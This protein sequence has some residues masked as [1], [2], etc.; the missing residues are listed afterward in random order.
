MKSA[1]WLALFALLAACKGDT[2]APGGKGDPGDPG[3]TGPGGSAAP[4]TGTLT[5]VVTDGIAHDALTSVAVT[6]TD[7]GGGALASATT[8]ASGKFSVTV[9]AGPVELTFVKA[10]Y[11]SPG[12]LQ[13]GVGIGET[14]QVAV[15]MNEAASGKPSLLLSA[16]GDDFGYGGSAAL[17]ATAADPN[18]DTLTYAWSNAGDPPLGTVSGN[19]ATGTIAFPT[20]AQAFASRADST[21]MQI[22]GYAIENRFGII[23]IITDTRGQVT[24]SLVVADGRGQATTASLTLNAAS[25][26]TG[27]R[28]VAVGQRIYLNSGH[29]TSNAWTLTAMPTGSSAA[30]DDPTLRT[31]SFV[32]DKVGEYSLTE[33]TH[34][35]TIT[36]SRWYGAITGGSGDSVTVDNTCL[37][38]HQNLSLSWIPDKFSPWLQTGH[39]TMFTRGINGELGSHYSGACIGCHTVGYDPGV[40]SGGFDEVAAANNWTFPVMQPTNWT[41][42]VA[43]EP[44]LAKLANIQC[45]NCHGPQGG[46]TA[47]TYSDAHM[48]T[49]I[50]P[51]T[52]RVS[53]PFQSPRISYSAELCGT[54]H[55][56][57]DHHIYSDWSTLSDDGMGHANRIAAQTIGSS[58]TT[59]SSSCGR[60]HTA[61]GYSLYSNLLKQNIVTMTCSP[62]ATCDPLGLLPT[63]ATLAQ[64]T[65]ANAE[66]VTC[67]S[68]HDPHDAT[69]PNQ[70][71]VYDSIAMTPAG[72]GVFGMGKGAVCVSCHNSRN[73][74]IATSDTFTYLHEDGQTY[75]GGNPTAYSAPHEADQ[76]D[77]FMGHNA[78]FMG[79]NMPMTSKHAAITDTCVGCHMTLQP[80]T[81]M[82]FGSPQPA[83]HKFGI[84]ETKLAQ[85]CSNCHGSAVD[86]AGIQGQVE[87]QLLAL[88]AKASNA[89]KAK[90]ATLPSPI[91]NVI[92]NDADGTTSPSFALDTSLYP[93]MSATFVEIHGQV[94]LQL[95]LATPVTIPWG[96]TATRTLSTFA[97]QLG[98]LKD[99]QATPAPVYALSGRFIRAGWNYFLIEGD[100]TKGLHNPSFVLAV[101]NNTLAQDLS[102]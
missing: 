38:C 18:G 21:G 96:G 10:D 76:G 47:G 80:D 13:T 41:N 35:I 46:A 71:R 79:T 8:D 20:M 91:L 50:G 19:G 92:A 14:V 88:Q 37:L 56:A 26:A 58:A 59:M 60:C 12:T 40:S 73:G 75:N 83:K 101:L 100:N 54:C 89:F 1:R 16:I 74:T 102:L 15:T 17:T 34:S 5:G 48:L 68:C 81:F 70:L 67:T 22:A 95:T 66:P 44:A 78:Y 94:S 23:P 90:L 2:G 24:A 57:G 30:L 97:V 82:A 84:D 63:A 28:N 69:N 98:S 93:I 32:L 55:G 6:A 64:V 49:A 61:Q 43:S 45:E 77:V 11:T 36:A 72:F 42:L 85:L 31:P 27:T 4:T 51:D 39:A 53:A 87:A 29:D 7:E 52:A 9:T 25:I 86:G 62:L 3:P 33:G 99:N 65:S